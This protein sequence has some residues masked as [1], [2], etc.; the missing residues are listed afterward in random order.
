MNKVLRVDL[1]THDFV[2]L[3]WI[4]TLAQ[5]DGSYPSEVLFNGSKFLHLQGKIYR[6][7][8]TLATDSLAASP[9][10][11]LSNMADRPTK[12]DRFGGELLD[13]GPLSELGNQGVTPAQILS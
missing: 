13:C 9:L 6:Q 11:K 4:R 5:D 7:E 12:R 8:Q 1:F 10:C 2:A 3:G